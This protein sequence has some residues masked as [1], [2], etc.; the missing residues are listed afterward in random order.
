M[1]CL[2][3]KK[4]DRLIILWERELDVSGLALR[5]TRRADA[6]RRAERLPQVEAERDA[7]RGKLR[8]TVHNLRGIGMPVEQIATVTGLT[9]DEIAA[10]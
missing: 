10:I 8:T 9:A 3:L 1:S 7:A 4:G 5:E 2:S 6:E